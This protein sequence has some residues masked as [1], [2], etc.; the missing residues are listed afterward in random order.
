M[1]RKLGA[2]RDWDLFA[3]HAVG[4]GWLAVR[5]WEPQLVRRSVPGPWPALRFA[6]PW[7]AL[8]IA[9]PWFAVNASRPAAL[10]RFAEVITD[11]APY[12][13]GYA[14]QDIAKYHR[15]R[16][17]HEL[18]ARWGEES[19]RIFPRS[20]RFHALL[21]ADYVALGRLEEAGREFDEALRIQP[22]DRAVFDM[23]A[24]LALRRGEFATA[25][26]LYERQSRLAPGDPEVWWGIGYAALQQR[27]FPAAREA[28]LRACSLRSDPQYD[29]LAGIACA[30]LERWDE[31]AERFR[32]AMRDD[33]QGRGALSLAMVLEAREA[34]RLAAGGGADSASLRAAAQAAER[35]ASL[36]VG[37][38]QVVAYRDHVVRVAA[39]LEPPTPM[40]R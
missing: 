19:V 12:Q 18:A 28:L 13:R 6:A 33:P 20:M 29:Y 32:L 22:T 30:S 17:D 37:D 31:A 35:A 27:D 2:A 36:A 1:D 7:V 39:G 5:L 8:L 9:W 26:S 34:A 21:G 23:R 38:P 15:D 4:L 10:K 24:K 40:P 16:G 14:A 11:F 25:R 3:P